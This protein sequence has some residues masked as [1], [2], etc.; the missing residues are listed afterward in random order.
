MWLWGSNARQASD[1]QSQDIMVMEMESGR[2]EGGRSSKEYWG[3]PRRLSR[4]GDRKACLQ[5]IQGDLGDTLLLSPALTE[6][7]VQQ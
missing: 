4:A 6:R 3:V 7:Q 1:M 2:E 5:V